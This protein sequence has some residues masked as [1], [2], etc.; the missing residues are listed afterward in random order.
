MRSQH[1]YAKRI[2]HTHKKRNCFFT[3][4][5]IWK[6]QIFYHAVCLPL[7]GVC[8]VILKMHNLITE[9]VFRRV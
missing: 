7:A 5:I 6:L 8:I 9:D 1:M 2:F 4:G 3:I